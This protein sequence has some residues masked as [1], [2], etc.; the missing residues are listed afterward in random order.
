MKR[1]F[2]MS[3][4]EVQRFW[5]RVDR[6][7]PDECW[8]WLNSRGQP[9]HFYGQFRCKGRSRLATHYVLALTSRPRPSNKM[10]A[11]HSC[12]NPPC[13]NP[14]HLRWGTQQENAQEAAER[15]RERVLSDEWGDY[16][17]SLGLDEIAIKRK[18]RL[19]PGQVLDLRAR[20]LARGIPG[21]A[22]FGSEAANKVG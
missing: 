15:R 13:C 11:L 1:P 10:F 3:K 19:T 7:S 8:P 4:E 16:L 12:D 22:S 20:A 17:L 9:Y 5:S 6:R 2:G 18:Y 14:A 21:F